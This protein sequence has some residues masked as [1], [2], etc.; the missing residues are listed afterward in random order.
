MT[1]AVATGSKSA[2]TAMLNVPRNSATSQRSRC[3]TGLVEIGDLSAHIRPHGRAGEPTKAHA[4]RM[5]RRTRIGACCATRAPRLASE[6]PAK[7]PVTPGG[8]CLYDVS[9]LRAS[10]RPRR[11]SYA[12]MCRPT[13][14][15]SSCCPNRY[16]APSPSTSLFGIYSS[17]V[18]IVRGRPARSS[19]CKLQLRRAPPMTTN[20][21][22]T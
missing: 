18:Q 17:A 14:F 12:H 2:R 7:R 13:S 15:L 5:A 21:C 6:A 16:R 20:T 8:A 1:S 3:A 4:P 19:S 9:T 10:H 11:P 22:F